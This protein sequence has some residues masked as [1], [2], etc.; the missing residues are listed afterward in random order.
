[1]P[2]GSSVPPGPH[3]GMGFVQFVCM[4]A[5]LMALGALGIDSMLPNLPTIASGLG[6]TDANREQWIITAYLL[7]FGGAQI[8]YGALSDRYGRKPVL[9]AGLAVYMVFS[10]V[11]A[12]APS[13]EL[14]LLA[15]VFQGFGAASTRTLPVS[16]VRDSYSGRQMARVMSLSFMV[17]LAVPVLAPT[18][19]QLIVLV[20][21]WRWIFGVLA[22][23]GGLVFVWVAVKL[24]E[25]L[26]PEDRVPIIPA[27]MAA[28]FAQVLK[29]R[30]GMGYGVAL[31]WVFGALFGFINSSQQIFAEAFHAPESF[32]L[33]FAIIASFIALASLLNARLVN[34][35]G[36]RMI[37][38]SAVLGFVILSIIHSA[39]AI[40]GHE[41]LITFTVL[42]AATMFTFGLI[43]GNFGAMAMEPLGHVA[44]AAASLQGTV[45]MVGGSLIG[46][47]IG[48][49][50]DGTTIPMSLG[51]AL[52]GLAAL[53]SVFYAERGR[54]FHPHNQ[55]EP[56]SRG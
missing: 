54:L 16:I 22:I 23:L 13:F 17:F 40:S 48:Q 49:H 46:F 19:G 52:C 37:S 4:I 33:S 29:S 56:P 11:A 18:L 39:V 14:L 34:R 20:A 3:R 30:R 55:P 2:A 47:F 43:S 27:R 44:G 10:V 50:F 12:L 45:S 6:V 53:A 51:Y 9:L 25:T 42:Q 15:R 35:L 24:P 38:H 41:T 31:T 5:A 28:A 7:G 32:T 26:H 21:P 1:M 36:M 8:V